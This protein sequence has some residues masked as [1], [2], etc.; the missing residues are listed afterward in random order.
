VR[1]A[2]AHEAFEIGLAGSSRLM[3]PA[4]A[5]APE[6]YWAAALD[7][8]VK[9]AGLRVWAEGYL[10]TTS[11]L[12]DVTP[13]MGDDPLFV[14]GRLL[15]AWRAGGREDNDWYL[16]PFVLVS[17]LDGNLDVAGDLVSEYAGGLAGGR[18]QRLR[19]QLQ[20]QA[21]R[22]GDN[23]SP[24]FVVNGEALADQEAVILQLGAAF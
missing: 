24:L 19:A 16:E 17:L 15:A 18:W 14:A 6:R 1:V 8:E 20:V 10:G 21:Y 9:L 11:K 7:A 4:P 3:V 22:E 13:A 2:L 5:A 23:A 12:F